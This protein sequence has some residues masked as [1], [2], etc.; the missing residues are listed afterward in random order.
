MRFFVIFSAA[1]TWAIAACGAAGY[2]IW[3]INPDRLDASIGDLSAA[4]GVLC[5]A[6]VL[7][8][9]GFVFAERLINGRR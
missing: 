3:R 6:G 1:L 2:V 4:L 9:G 5:A 8:V 7:V